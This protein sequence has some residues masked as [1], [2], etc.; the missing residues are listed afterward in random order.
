MIFLGIDT[1]NYTTSVYAVDKSNIRGRRKLLEVKPGER[2][3]RQSDG[4]F[5]HMKGFPLLFGE[6]CSE[7][8]VT[9]IGAVGVSTR[10]RSIEGSYMPVFLAGSGYA[11]AIAR[12][13][14][15]PKYEYSHQDGHIMAGVRSC[16]RYSL[17][18]DEFISVH[19]SGGTTEIL[20]T[21]YNGR[22]FDC[23]ITG[24]TKDISAGQLIDRIGVAMGLKFPAGAELERLA[25][26]A[27]SRISLPIK[28]DGAWMNLSGVETKALRMLEDSRTD[29]SALAMGV[30]YEI[31]RALVKT[32][33]AALKETGLNRVLIAGGVAS[34]SIIREGL[35]SMPYDVE[36]ASK[37]FSSDNAMGI[38]ELARLEYDKEYGNKNRNSISD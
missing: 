21:R 34:N 10:P 19:I 38:A 5:Q 4:V 30:L 35:L 1:S 14:N 7:I 11:E 24:G 2:G 3:L 12:A 23:R 16:E 26:N 17:L 15:V 31:K 29:K 8:D 20:K 18:E 33:T 37:E 6:L 9:Q 27:D 22:G 36:F 25:L 32:I 13:L 28:T